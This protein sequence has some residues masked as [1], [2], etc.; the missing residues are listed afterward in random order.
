MR[1]TLA[2]VVAL[3]PALAV[4]FHE[5]GSTTKCTAGDACSYSYL[6]STGKT[7]TLSG[8]CSPEGHCGDN[9]AKCS[10]STSCYNDCS[11]DGDAAACCTQELFTHNQVQLGCDTARAFKCTINVGRGTCQK[12]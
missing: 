3:L 5:V 10:S 9:G 8:F 2:A 1:F 12:A 11:D 4:A 7:A 6:A